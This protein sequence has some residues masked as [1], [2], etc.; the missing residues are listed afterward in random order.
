MAQVKKFTPEEI[1]R[2]IKRNFLR[3]ENVR[4]S[5]DDQ[6][7]DSLIQSV[8]EEFA[9]GVRYD[10]Y[11]TRENVWDY[12]RNLTSGVGMASL[13]GYHPR[14]KRSAVTSLIFAVDGN[15]R[16]F[17][18]FSENV[19]EEVLDEDGSLDVL[20]EGVPGVVDYHNLRSLR[21]FPGTGTNPELE[22]PI[23][24]VIQ[25]RESE[26]QYITLESRSIRFA[27]SLRADQD[28]DEDSTSRWA[29]IP[30][31]QGIRRE[32]TARGV[33][34]REFERVT[35]NSKNV[36]DMRDPYSEDF[37]QVWV[38]TPGSDDFEEW[39]RLNDVREAGPYDRVYMVETELDYSRVHIVFGNG[40]TGRRIP[41]GTDVRVNYLET[42]GSE[43]NIDETQ[44]LTEFRT[45]LEMPYAGV[46]LYVTNLNPVV[47]GV[48]EDT[49]SDIKARAP[50]HYLTVE[51][52]GSEE[53]YVAAIESLPDVR[54]AR[55]YRG[56][57]R[58]NQADTIRDT[59]SFTAIAED[60]SAPQELD[61]VRR[62]RLALGRKTSPTDIL[63][64]DPPE[65]VG[66]AYNVRGYIDDITKPLQFFVNEVRRILY[67][68][69]RIREMEFK[70]SIFHID[71]MAALRNGIEALEAAQAFPEAVLESEF[72]RDTF[73]LGDE[74][75]LR[76]NFNFNSSLAPFREIRH[77]VEHVLRVDFIVRPEGIRHRSRTILLVPAG[78]DSNDDYIIRQF[79]L[80]ED[81]VLTPD[82]VRAILNDTFGTYGEKTETVW[83]WV[84]R[85]TLEAGDPEEDDPNEFDYYLDGNELKLSPV[86]ESKLEFE[87][88]S[89]YQ[90]TY[91][92]VEEEGEY[93]VEGEVRLYYSTVVDIG[94]MD[95][96][97]LRD[98]FEQ[99]REW[100][101]S[102]WAKDDIVAASLVEDRHFGTF[103]TVYAPDSSHRA[104]V[105]LTFQA[106][107]TEDG[108]QAGSG[109]IFI[110]PEFQGRQVDFVPPT[111]PYRGMTE[112]DEPV[113]CDIRVY[114]MPR[115]LDLMLE[116]DFSIFNLTQ[117]NIKVDLRYRTDADT[118]FQVAVDRET[119]DVE[120]ED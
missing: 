85:T 93:T 113:P 90:L 68:K 28:P 61:I 21:H 18:A 16:N 58:R 6:V 39:E 51:S 9:E 98:Y 2:R 111:I 72:Y 55:V 67:T 75:A 7:V 119:I 95:Q 12:I 5:V 91:T 81:I 42:R 114:A 65:R 107:G 38:R 34:G 97:E 48:D 44:R 53:A 88:D 57:Y 4:S 52:V 70:E 64:Y 23:H 106:S 94:S 47:N 110:R 71:V 10:E 46:T 82:R 80:L 104:P 30:A 25:D 101:E 109:S 26:I 86:L 11:L 3:R 22:I 73:I 8:A 15:I 17:G 31:I 120:D 118:E 66:I 83:H 13:V 1:S 108:V 37:L 92:I 100:K 49:L 84:N 78:E 14:R 76:Q 41:R 19:W 99:H 87:S 102:E 36:E 116:D 74:G 96:D 32:F 45:N 27:G 103:P 117:D 33:R 77:N 35:I 89:N 54:R 115:R 105:E 56:I 29:R 24:T 59:V 50:Q 112:D 20:R 79:D 60:G 69:Y 40:I 63:Q 62:V 43:G